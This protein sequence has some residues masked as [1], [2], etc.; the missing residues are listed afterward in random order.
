MRSQPLCRAVLIVTILALATPDANG[1]IMYWT[2]PEVSTISRAMT[3]GT[4][5]Q[6]IIT[7]T[8]P[9][10]IALDTTQGKIYWTDDVL[11]VVQ[12]SNLDGTGKEVLVYD[13]GH[14]GNIT[15]NLA[16]Q[17]MYWVDL[18]AD[19]VRS[20]D[21]NGDNMAIILAPI[22]LVS[23]RYVEV[24]R[25][26]GHLYVSGRRFGSGLQGVIFRLNSDGS[27]L[28]PLLEGL[29]SPQRMAVDSTAGKIYWADSTL[30]T[31]TRADL[32]GANLE[33]IVSSGLSNP[34]DVALDLPGGKCYWVE[35]TRIG[36]CNL[37]GSEIE[38][39][40]TT[41]LFS[42]RDIALDN[43][44]SGQ[45]DGIP[46]QN[47]NEC[48]SDDR[49]LG[50]KCVGTSFPGPCDDGNQCTV[51][52][53]CL[54]GECTATYDPSS[55]F[56][57][58]LLVTKVNGDECPSCPTANLP[59]DE[60]MPGDLITIEAYL[61]NWNEDL[62]IGR[63]QNGDPCALSGQ[64]CSAMHCRQNPDLSC[65]LDEQCSF[66]GPCESDYCLPGPSVGAY[67]WTLDFD[68]L[69]AGL[70]GE[71]SPLEVPC[72]TSADCEHGLPICTCD[73]AA[74][75]NSTCNLRGALYIDGTRPDLL[76]A[77]TSSYIIYWGE[78]P[79]GPFPGVGAVALGPGVLD[80]GHP[81]YLGTLLLK[82]SPDA[83]GT[84]TVDVD[85][86][87]DYTFVANEN[88]QLIR[89]LEIVP[90]LIN[91]CETVESPN[92][93]N[94]NDIPDE[95]EDDGDGDG[96]IDECDPCA[97]GHDSDGDGVCDSDDGCP[98]NPAKTAPGLCGCDLIDD[99]DSDGDGVIDCIDSCPG[100][101]D[102]LFAPGCTAAIPAASHWGL[103]AMVLSLL[104]T[105]KIA[106]GNRLK[107][108][109]F[110]CKNSVVRFHGDAT[111]R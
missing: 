66:Y 8:Y 104:A 103:L 72:Q 108:K 26:S 10:G 28:T 53:H 70:G 13:A 56:Q 29:G 77:N 81:V 18:N 25:L 67:Q 64:D 19:Q 52:D 37:D 93:C 50:G 2:D 38:S 14:S 85:P 39:V 84:F 74:C 17:K 65:T 102:G 35:S 78:S 100:V 21:L 20:A 30:D 48:D 97:N 24:D 82:V 106:F 43:Y 87:L 75:N 60:V 63:C 22:P 46:C 99:G 69:S 86:S 89:P 11:Q 95:C 27:N 12:R 3:D 105:A 80:P 6:N 76:V 33:T 4:N 73:G 79:F 68:G 59:A 88:G 42:P 83:R 31:I 34:I 91:L 7:T 45:P 9:V 101:S 1:Q 55:C 32:N 92:D 54:N 16:A 49:C 51:N 107:K 90:A 71:L 23:L 96:I 15:L 5:R 40:T 94:N 41:N 62:E 111:A 110:F 58:F 57:F 98:N 44:C 61:E 36:R 109:P 47:L